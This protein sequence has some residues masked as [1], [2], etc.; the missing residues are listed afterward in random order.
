M[1][2]DVDVSKIYTALL[3]MPGMNDLIREDLTIT[4][5]QEL[6]FCYFESRLK[7]LEESLKIG[8]HLDDSSFVFFKN[9]EKEKCCS[10]LNKIQL[11]QLFYILMDEGILF[12]NIID[13]VKN[14]NKIQE[15]IAENFTYSGDSGNQMRITTISKQ[16]S[17]CKG[18]TYRETQLSFLNELILIIE[19]RRDKLIHW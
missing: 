18:Y 3:G 17:E 16:F 13:K 11:A 12:F 6:M 14:R 15:F 8:K 2:V 19:K 10:R 7:I 9:G 5:E 1:M 4:K